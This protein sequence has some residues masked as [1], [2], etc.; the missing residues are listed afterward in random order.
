MPR[1]QLL[2]VFEISADCSSQLG[3]IQKT[4]V[5]G[6]ELSPPMLKTSGLHE[7]SLIPRKYIIIYLQICCLAFFNWVC[8]PLRF[9]AKSS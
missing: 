3:Q 2:C 7:V 6:Y 8:P 1:A 5:R 9:V 4:S